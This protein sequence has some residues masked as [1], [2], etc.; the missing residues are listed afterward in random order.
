MRRRIWFQFAALAVVFLVL[1]VG[2]VGYAYLGMYNV[3]A[4]EKHW[5]ATQSLLETVRTRSIQARSRG[6]RDVPN[7]EDPKLISIGAGQYAEMCVQCHLAP[8]RK[9]SPLREG[10]YPQPPDLSL[11]SLEP[12]A[13]FWVVKH[14][15]KMTGMP[16]WGASHDDA[17]IW[18]LVA[19]LQKL[20]GLDAKAY[21]NMTA[22][23]PADESMPGMKG[24]P[25]GGAKGSTHTHRDSKAHGH[26]K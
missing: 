24:M 18:G 5:A 13:A 25:S 19:F 16:A 22:E 2:G 11:E 20:P 3:A 23:A 4:D 17:T 8:G 7:L 26:P 1:V 21:E 15:I 14:G 6:I 12:R 10:L 9:D